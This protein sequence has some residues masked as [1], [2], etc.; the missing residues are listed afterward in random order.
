MIDENT[1]TDVLV[2]RGHNDIFTTIEP[3]IISVKVHLI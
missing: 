3:G 1:L 2:V